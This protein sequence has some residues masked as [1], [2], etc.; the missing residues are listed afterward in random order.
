MN[1]E[2]R[3]AALE[4]AIS[5]HAPPPKPT[6]SQASEYLPPIP[7]HAAGPGAVINPTWSKREQEAS[8]P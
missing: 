1:I 4:D 6:R 5:A 7:L 8:G 3:L 2:E